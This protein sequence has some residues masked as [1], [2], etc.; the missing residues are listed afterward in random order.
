MLFVLKWLVQ[1][2][3]DKRMLAIGIACVLN[4]RTVAIGIADSFGEQ[5]AMNIAHTLD[6]RWPCNF[7]THACVIQRWWPIS[8]FGQTPNRKHQRHIVRDLYIVLDNGATA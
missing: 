2:V 6:E 1:L 8:P 3:L 4:E 7:R 5:M